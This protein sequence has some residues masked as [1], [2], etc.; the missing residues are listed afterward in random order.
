MDPRASTDATV[1]LVSNK[2]DPASPTKWFTAW[3]ISLACALTACVATT[4]GILLSPVPS[5]TSNNPLPPAVLPVASSALW[6][7]VNQPDSSFSWNDTKVSLSGNFSG[8]PWD[9]YLLNMTSGTWL[10]PADSTCSKWSHQVLVVVP[11]TLSPVWS[12]DNA[13]LYI[14]G[15]ST[16]SGIPQPD[17][18]DVMIAAALATSTGAI[19]AVLWQ[20]P[21]QPCLFAADPK[22]QQRVEDD[23]IAFTWNQYLANTSRPDWIVFFPMTRACS[24]AMDAVTA[25]V[26]G[27][28]G[29]QY[30]LQNWL[31]SGASKRGWT[32]WWTGVVEARV[33]LIAPLVMDL[34]N[35][36]PGVEN[37]WTSLGNWTYVFQP[38]YDEAIPALFGTPEVNA[39]LP[40]IDPLLSKA[41]L[42]MPKLVVTAAGDEFFLLD[43]DRYWWGQLP[44]E[45]L[46]LIEKNAEH[47]LYNVIP[48]V[49]TSVA[50]F[51]L[52]A[53]SNA[54]RPTYNWTIDLK[55]GTITAEVFGPLQPVAVNATSTTTLPGSCKQNVTC[56]ARRDF[57]LATG[58]TEWDPCPYIPMDIF[59]SACLR[60]ITWSGHTISPIFQN[61]TYSKW[62]VQQDFPPEG[63]WNAFMLEFYFLGPLPGTPYKLTTQAAVIPDTKPFLP[64]AAEDCMKSLV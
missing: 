53:L 13:A 25:F 26:Q 45:S 61:A 30:S 6:T 43:N 31:T 10:T 21:N 64:C 39:L 48:S 59:G 42:S 51:W 9:G 3:K 17:S 40:F 34:L 58:N 38:Y 29:P 14:T 1:L 2:V 47:S 56:T 62:F 19:T 49:I 33:K 22:Q 52:S 41:N 27:K 63:Y 35:F 8:L 44:G 54:P 5:K 37:M 18:D 23:I 11:K 46:R 55:Q 28:F 12:L 50:T 36:L 24:R 15:G 32:T 16:S 57:R 4:L 7:Y 20:V 60:P